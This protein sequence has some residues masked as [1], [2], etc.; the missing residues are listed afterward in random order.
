MNAPPGPRALRD[1]FGTFATGVTIIT[2]TKP[3][4]E[5]A[6]VTVNSFTSVSLAPPQLLWC[7]QQDSTS[8]D[9]FAPHRA[10]A[11][12]VL[13]QGQEALAMHFARR[14]TVKFPHGANPAGD[15]A[16]LIDGALCRLDGTVEAQHAGGDHVIIVGRVSAVTFGTGDP[17]VFQAGVFGRFAPLPRAR[18]V[19]AWETFEGDWF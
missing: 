6:G 10:F 12:H 2:G 18:H 3:G 15:A 16:P 11:V 8:M 7:L 5:P 14:A 1:A 17:L 19:E 4:G 9:A 13:A